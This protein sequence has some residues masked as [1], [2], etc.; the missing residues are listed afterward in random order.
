MSTEENKALVRRIFEEVFN[1][2]NVTVM[3]ELATLDLTVHYAA[4]A[5]SVRGRDA[6]K[7]LFM[8]SRSCSL[9]AVRSVWFAVAG[10]PRAPPHQKS[11][12]RHP[13]AYHLGGHDN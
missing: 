10:C 8:A 2:G 3:D 9:L 11:H 1:Q 4:A 13:Q 5:E 12:R 7:Q 6:Y